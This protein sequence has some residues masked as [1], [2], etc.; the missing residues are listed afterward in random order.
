VLGDKI[1]APRFAKDFS[2]QMLHAWKLG[3]HHPRTG[4][5]KSFEAPLPDDFT[6]AIAAMGLTTRLQTTDHQTNE[7]G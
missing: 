7:S 1:Y 3:F 4:E 6:C 2:R 5:W